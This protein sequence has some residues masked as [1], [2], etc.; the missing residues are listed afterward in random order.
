MKRVSS[1]KGISK[2][3]VSVLNRKCNE[4]QKHLQTI[5][6][7]KLAEIW[8]ILPYVIMYM[9]VCVYTKINTHSVYLYKDLYTQGYSFFSSHMRGGS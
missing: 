3:G 4:K 6:N 7:F 8:V 5:Q 2:V 9:Y 1:E